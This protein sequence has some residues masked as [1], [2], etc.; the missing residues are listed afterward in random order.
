MSPLRTRKVQ[1][2]V[3]TDKLWI[4]PSRPVRERES[5]NKTLVSYDVRKSLRT[6]KGRRVSGLKNRGTKGQKVPKEKNNRVQ[7]TSKRV[8]EKVRDQIEL[9]NTV[10]TVESKGKFDERAKKNNIVLTVDCI[11]CGTWMAT[12]GISFA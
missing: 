6:S 8:G 11:L 12:Y 2:V 4:P 5:A 10:L 9:K 3:D 1:K 7:I